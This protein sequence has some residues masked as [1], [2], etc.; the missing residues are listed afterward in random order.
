MRIIILAALLVVLGFI[1]WQAVE[2]FQLLEPE[3]PNPPVPEASQ[4]D[5]APQS[6]PLPI[7]PVAPSFDLVRVGRD[8]YAVIA[9]R[10]VGGAS[11]QILANDAVLTEIVIDP[12]GQ[13]TVTTDTPLEGGTVELSLTMTTLDGVTLKSEET[14]VIY[15]PEA[16]ERPLVLR[17]TPGGATEVLQTPRDRSEGYGPLSLDSIDYDNSETVIFSGRADPNRTVQILA[18]RQM[19][20]SVQADSTGRWSLSRAMAPGVYSLLVIQLDENGRP[21]YVIELPFERATSE[22]IALRDG[23]VVVQPGNSL[24]RI[25]RRAYGSGAQYTI[26]FEANVDQIRDP[27]L[28]FPGQ[29]FSVPGADDEAEDDNNNSGDTSEEDEDS[30]ENNNL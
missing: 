29:I 24:W 23:R 15:V 25:A 22:Q 20:G 9:G 4:P 8:G 2:R 1:A 12:D 30:P 6:D 11:L 28:I 19:I 16:G 18:N 26:I 3:T 10:G 14:V 5:P 17:T 21:E 7:G 27:D 13:W